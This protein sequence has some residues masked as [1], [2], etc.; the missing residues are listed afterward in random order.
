[1][2]T[3]NI[4]NQ[5]LVFVVIFLISIGYASGSSNDSQLDLQ[6]DFIK[7]LVNDAKQRIADSNNISDSIFMVIRSGYD[8]MTFLQEKFKD[9]LENESP[10]KRFKYTKAIVLGGLSGGVIAGVLIGL[11][12]SRPGEQNEETGIISDFPPSDP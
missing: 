8:P 3:K 2:I 7:T 12:T 10:K 4:K 11:F 6:R 9:Q 5:V 1:M